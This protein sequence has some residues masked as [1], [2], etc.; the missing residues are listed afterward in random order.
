M[1]TH[2]LSLQYRHRSFIS[3]SKT[4]A[5][6]FAISFRRSVHH[7]L[8]LLPGFL[9]SITV[10]LKPQLGYLTCT[11]ASVVQS[12]LMLQISLLCT[13]LRLGKYSQFHVITLFLNSFPGSSLKTKQN[14]EISSS[15]STPNF[16]TMIKFPLPHFIIKLYRHSLPLKDNC[17]ST[18]YLWE[19]GDI[20]KR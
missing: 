7:T 12:P 3:V 14:T 17:T 1:Q 10:P 20:S 6:F 2:C 9:L 5:L 18:L 13:S 16:Y 19:K 11:V 8:Q 4:I 15:W